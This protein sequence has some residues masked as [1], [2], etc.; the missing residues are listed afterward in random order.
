MPSV[1]SFFNNFRDYDASFGDKL[2]LA[3]K[4]T[5]IKM[6]NKSDCCGNHGEPGC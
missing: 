3:A 5:R 6:K 2:R 1:R 4:N